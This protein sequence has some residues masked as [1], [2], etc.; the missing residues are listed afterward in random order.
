MDKDPILLRLFYA[1]GFFVVYRLL[2]V[3]VV[4][5]T[6]VQFAHQLFIGEP[7]TDLTAFGRNLAAYI[8]Q[9]ANYL[10]W[11]SDEKPFPFSDWPS[12][13]SKKSD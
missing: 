3:V 10:F 5:I 9:I 2:D 4:I 12:V 6:I 7:H 11:S 13:N 8:A 1:I